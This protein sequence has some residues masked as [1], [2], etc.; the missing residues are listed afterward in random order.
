VRQQQASNF[1]Q[2]KIAFAAIDSNV[3]LWSFCRSFQIMLSSTF[4]HR[5]SATTLLQ[6]GDKFASTT[7]F[8]G[9]RICFCFFDNL[10]GPSA[11][12]PH[13]IQPWSEG[14]PEFN[15]F[16]NYQKGCV[17]HVRCIH[18]SDLN[19]VGSITLIKPHYLFPFSLSNPFVADVGGHLAESRTS[20]QYCP[21]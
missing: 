18:S 15:P 2:R 17:G 21:P 6:K 13:A 1:K 14:L 7:L 16:R 9:V 10:E 11:V 12:D 20:T 5:Y 3:W 4:R 19:N 8:S